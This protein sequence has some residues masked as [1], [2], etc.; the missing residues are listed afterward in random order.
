MTGYFT[1]PSVSWGPAAIEQL[2][3]LGARKA[4]VLAD[5]FFKGRP[6]VVR[7]VEELTKS[8]ASVEVSHAVVSEP[9]VASVETAAEALRSAHPDWIVALGGGSALDT[10]RAAWCRLAQPKVPL[11][12]I[13]P[14]VE[15]RARAQARFVAIPT[16][17]G[18]GSDAAWVAHIRT[19][20]GRPLEVGTRELSADWALVDPDLARSVPAPRAAEHGAD[21]VAHALEA[22]LSEWSNP[23]SD[24]MAREAVA[25][26]LPALARVTRHPDETDG[27]D[28]LHYA[29]TLAG[30]AAANAEVGV[31]HA[32]AHA[33]GG[34]TGL[35]HARLVAAL[36]PTAMEYD[37]PSCREK[38]QGLTGVVGPSVA[39]S[40]PALAD[41]LRATFEAAGLP[42]SLAAAGVPEATVRDGR[43]QVIEWARG[44]SGLV[45][46]PRIPSSEELGR[47]LDAAFAGQPVTF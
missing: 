27:R 3:A 28:A 39:Q 5:P 40:R 42:R 37:F 7:V 29:A 14:L 23:F 1:V 12:Q 33:L 8:D 47:L 18:S 34:V 22:L 43:K 21:A 4:F 6:G 10:A 25:R 41:K 11:D 17:S 46:N 31:A 15:L 30:I 19:A 45:A 13:T 36:L 2:S 24:A 9:T 38:L 16:T 26:A 20:E 32:L 44:S 35:P